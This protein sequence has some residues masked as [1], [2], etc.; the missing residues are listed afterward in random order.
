MK[1][2]SNVYRAAICAVISVAFISGCVAAIPI[3]VHYYKTHN[4]YVATAEVRKKADDLW[5][6]VVK[7][8]DERAAQSSNDNFKILKKNDADR[9]L[10]ATD[11]VQVASVKI[12]STGR[13]K[14]KVVITADSPEGKGEE[15]DREKELAARIMKNLCQ[16]AKA[17]CQLAEE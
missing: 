3:A 11:G 17:E 14:S 4:N 6:A 5:E 1:L 9:L 2:N 13:R 15:L 7:L 10:E 16:E 12:I 8:A